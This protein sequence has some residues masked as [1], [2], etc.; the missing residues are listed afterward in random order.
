VSE[1]LQTGPATGP[2]TPPAPPP[3]QV[4]EEDDSAAT[5]E[6]E[7]ALLVDDNRLVRSSLVMMLEDIGF[8]VI[9]AETAHEALAALNAAP[10]IDVALVDF[11]L[12]D[13]NGLELASRIRG[14][15][16]DLRLAVVSGQPVGPADLAK[17]PGPPVGMLLKPFTAKQLEDLLY[18]NISEH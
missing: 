10:R 13:M 11:R 16:P 15:K 5:D 14:I 17:I 2:A 1:V 3:P 12:P 6:E 7:I 18:G 4:G 9:E 8:A